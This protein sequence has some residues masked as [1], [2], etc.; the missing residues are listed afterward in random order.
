M[1]ILSTL[2]IFKIISFSLIAVNHFV[3]AKL[4][5]LLIE[6]SDQELI[7]ITDFIFIIYLTCK[8]QSFAL[9]KNEQNYVGNWNSTRILEYKKTNWTIE[10]QL[11]RVFLVSQVSLN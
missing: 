7:Y 4:F 2:L 5:F 10:M 3:H 8:E 9:Q 11:E 6:K 1:R